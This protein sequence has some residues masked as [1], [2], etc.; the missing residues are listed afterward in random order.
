[1]SENRPNLTRA[2]RFWGIGSIF[3]LM[4]QGSILMGVYYTNDV[5]DFF[6]ILRISCFIIVI[7]GVFII[8]GF[9]YFFLSIKTKEYKK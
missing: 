9:F 4:A 2:L 6:K 1:M 7:S 3:I 8:I 5:N